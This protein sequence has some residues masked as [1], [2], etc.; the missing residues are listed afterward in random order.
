MAVN[1]AQ[2]AQASNIVVWYNLQFLTSTFNYDAEQIL[3]ALMYVLHKGRLYCYTKK[4]SVE[5]SIKEVSLSFSF[6][7][8]FFFLSEQTYRILPYNIFYLQ[9]NG[10]Y[11]IITRCTIWLVTNIETNLNARLV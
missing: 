3:Q 2:Q 8:L 9:L 5:K 7:Y 6:M 10:F 11:S 4:K 1:I